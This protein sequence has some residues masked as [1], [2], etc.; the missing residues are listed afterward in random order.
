MNLPEPER[1]LLEK[2]GREKDKRMNLEVLE[3]CAPSP[4][5]FTFTTSGGESSNLYV[6]N[7]AYQK[8]LP[9]IIAIKF[10]LSV[11]RWTRHSFKGR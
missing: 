9:K 5:I 11:S 8:M 7:T 4:L 6:H 1:T 10:T 3:N 2:N